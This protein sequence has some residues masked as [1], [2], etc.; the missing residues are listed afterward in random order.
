MVPFQAD[1]LTVVLGE[2]RLLERTR[3][4]ASLPNMREVPLICRRRPAI[5]TLGYWKDAS[6]V[7]VHAAARVCGDLSDFRMFWDHQWII[8]DPLFID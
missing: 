6:G 4:S 5:V 3:N 2:L 7:N 1:R 8:P